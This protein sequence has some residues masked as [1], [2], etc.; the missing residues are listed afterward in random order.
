MNRARDRLASLR[1][2]NKR[3]RTWVLQNG[4]TLTPGRPAASTQVTPSP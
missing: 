3:L 2:E 4:L 1:Q